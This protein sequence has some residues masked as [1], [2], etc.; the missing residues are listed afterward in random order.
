VV[1]PF[2][3][4]TVATAFADMVYMLPAAVAEK[5]LE[6]KNQKVDEKIKKMAKSSKNN[7]DMVSVMGEDVTRQYETDG[8]F[9]GAASLMNPYS[10]TK[11][12]GS[13]EAPA[14][15]NDNP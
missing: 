1:V 6:K 11:L 9:Y 3:S 4:D 13:F 14:S 7:R 12:V 8:K 15:A 10:L 2:G 5:A